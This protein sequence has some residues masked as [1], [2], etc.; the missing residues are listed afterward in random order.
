MINACGGMVLEIVFF[1]NYRI[2]VPVLPKKAK[3]LDK[4]RMTFY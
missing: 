1:P 2:W 3:R 4:N